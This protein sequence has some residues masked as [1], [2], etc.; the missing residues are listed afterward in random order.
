V[1]T[2][3]DNDFGMDMKRWPVLLLLFFV[4]IWLTL[5]G[6]NRLY[7]AGRGKNKVGVGGAAQDES[8]RGVSRTI[9]ADCIVTF[10]KADASIY[11]SE[12]RHTIHPQSQGLEISGTEP[13]GQFTWELLG[14]DFR[15][16]EG[17][18]NVGELPGVMY[19]RK[20]AK[21]ILT[22][23]VAGSGM[24]AQLSESFELVKIQGRW[25]SFIQI[26]RG[27]TSKKLKSF[28]VPWANL[29][30]YGDS[31]RGVIDRVVIEDITSGER[32]MAYSYNFRLLKGMDK[33]IP[34][35]IDVFKVNATQTEQ[36]RLLSIT[37]HTMRTR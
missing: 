33:S 7:I 9:V 16:V 34:T 8:G 4:L 36:K 13:G 14:G 32:L 10:Y 25:Y 5:S 37:Y 24:S 28:E 20:I 27:T 3:T 21:L 30:L 26:G 22:G 6:C 29:M 17:T 23:I 18:A 11:L 19:D 2:K 1:G 15:A 31:S 35:K 12:Q